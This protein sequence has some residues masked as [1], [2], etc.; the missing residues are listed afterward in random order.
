MMRRLTHV[1]RNRLGLR[2][3]TIL[4]AFLL[5]LSLA[6]VAGAQEKE[7][8]VTLNCVNE[9]LPDAL[10]KIER[11]SSYKVVFSYDELNT[12]RVSANIKQMPAPAAVKKLI[13]G[14]PLSST[15]NGR[16]IHVFLKKDQDN[17][18]RGLL[19]GQVV[20]ENDDPL[21]GVTVRVKGHRSVGTTTDSD[22]YF[23][24]PTK[25]GKSEVLVFSYVGKKGT[26]R[27]VSGRANTKIIMYDMANDI[28]EVVVTGYQELDRRKSTAAITSLKMDDIL[29][30]DMTTIDQALEGKVPDLMYT[31]NSGTVGSTAR[32]RV[33]GTST[34]IGNREPLWV[35]D[36]FI[37][38][39]PVAV[40]ADQLNDPDYVNYV[41]NAISGINPQDIERIDVLKDA[42]AT[43]LYGTRAAN[44]VIVVTTKHGKEGP[45]SVK[46]STQMKFSKRPRYTDSNINLMNSQERVQFGKDLCDLHYV[47]PTNMPMVGYEGAYY[48]YQQG[49]TSYD[50]FLN[51]VKWYETTNTDWLDILCQDALTQNYSLSLSGG[52]DRTRYYT[53]FGATDERGNVK[54]EYVRRYTAAMN[55]NTSFSNQLRLTVSMNANVQDKNHV[56]Q[57]VNVM[58]YAY[59]T[60]RAL[61]AY[62]P[63]GTLFYYKRHA[64]SVGDGSKNSYLYN[65]NIF[66]EIN[67]SNDDYR[68]NTIQAQAQ[69][70]YKLFPSLDITAAAH[71]SRSS[72]LQS[73]W[74][75]ENTNYVAILKNGEAADI[76]E[77]G[78]AGKCELP[79]GGVFN[80]R[81]TITE[82]A[83]GRIQA[84]FRKAYGAEQ[85]HLITATAGFEASKYSSDGIADDT[86]G[87]YKN[88]GLQYANLSGTDLDNFPLYKNWLANS[89][90]TLTAART[91]KISGYL[92]TTYDFYSYFTIGLNGRFDASNKFGSRSREKFLPVWSVSGR[93]D[94]KDIF[95]KEITWIDNW[96]LRGSY[97]KTGNMLDNETPNML[98]RQGAMDSYY[99]ENI[100]YVT[101]FPNP[102][103]RWEQTSSINAGT[104]LSLFNGRVNLTS[105]FWY[106]HTADAFSAINVSS[107]NGKSS[108]NMNNGVIDNHG[109]SIYISG[110]PWRDRDWSVYISTGYSWASN[111]VRS[112]ANDNFSLNDYLN[113]T[114]IMDGTSI[115]TF[116]SYRYLGLN[117]NTGIPMFDDYND[118]RHLLSKKKLHE[119][120]PL[121]MTATGNRD[122]KLT[123]SF[124]TS[125]KYRSFSVN[126]NFNYRLGSKVRLF[127]L[128]TPIVN[129]ISS[130]KN[131]RKEF[132]NRWQKP[133]DEAYTN[134]PVILSPSDP[135]YSATM[136]HW[137]KSLSGRVTD[138]I[139]DFAGNT[140]TMYDYSDLRVVSGDFL[141]LSNLVFNYQ[142]A[143]RLLKQ[144]FIKN[145]TVNFAMTNLF[146]LKSKELDGQDPLQ[147]NSTS[148]NMSLRPAYTFGLNISF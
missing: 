119:I 68:G 57:A 63:D 64:Y 94:I 108:Y 42:A 43:A 46:F 11:Q 133:G 131:V 117:P 107:I 99:G 95:C 54:S 140:W 128:Y 5:S 27:K 129:G 105:D 145:L 2:S 142:I 56:P 85:Q 98:I 45:P 113:G 102:N 9:K 90:R 31:Q 6:T 101:A 39:D 92:T 148:I 29:T 33:R 103:L 77:G 10:K 61:P 12:I 65:Y 30:P 83:T 118:R 15:V 32:L 36:G 100:S 89:H 127:N 124:Y 84:N 44:G 146:T 104:D 86:R 24:L 25:D 69:L 48:R 79:Y 135:N 50:Q 60:T 126:M 97:G 134:I 88:R 141:R 72:T 71:Y 96:K 66:N 109:Y 115:G 138:K 130:D 78:S 58:N 17:A 116:Y 137:C 35:L 123:G 132:L 82:N 55:I 143:P 26:E 74:F 49:K 112:G 144:Y 7:K 13:A 28:D 121:V 139:P 80:T 20:D 4:V 59:E 14:Q 40:S 136:S 52:S 122:P 23:S 106:K 37:L 81:N 114:A 125:I 16:Y 22:G 111:M 91:N 67:N 75:G 8:N 147:A 53:S 62:N 70:S 18:D 87:F 19:R 3:W 51:E 76:P 38:E 21:C 120:I 73:T 1:L 41:G 34:L 110:Y 93:L 47:F